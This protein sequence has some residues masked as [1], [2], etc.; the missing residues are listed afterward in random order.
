MLNIW[1]PPRI[2]LDA[3]ALHNQNEEAENIDILIMC[4]TQL[5]TWNIPYFSIVVLWT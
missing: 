5:N 1:Q 4:I 3:G 2:G